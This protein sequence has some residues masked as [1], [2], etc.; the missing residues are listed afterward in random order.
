MVGTPLVN[1]NY[2]FCTRVSDI[3]NMMTHVWFGFSYET[4][5]LGLVE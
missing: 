1:N 4:C 3:V 2:V 5:V